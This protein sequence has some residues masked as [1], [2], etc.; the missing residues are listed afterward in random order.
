[1]K[2]STDVIAQFHE[3]GTTY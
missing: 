3:Q 2:F 1:M